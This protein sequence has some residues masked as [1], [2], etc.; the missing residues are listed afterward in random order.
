[1]LTIHTYIKMINMA[2]SAELE[3]CLAA[4]AQLLLWLTKMFSE[5][6]WLSVGPLAHSSLSIHNRTVLILPQY[7]CLAGKWAGTPYLYSVLI[8]YLLAYLS[9]VLL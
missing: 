6:M 8:S 5:F 4:I 2:I 3:S 9:C 1:M 7:I